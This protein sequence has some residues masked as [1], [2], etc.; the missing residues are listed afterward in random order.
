VEPKTLPPD[1]ADIK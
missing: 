1:L